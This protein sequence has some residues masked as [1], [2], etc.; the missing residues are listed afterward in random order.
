MPVLLTSFGVSKYLDKSWTCY[1]IARRQPKG[2]AYPTLSFLAPRDSH[3]RSLLLRLFKKNPAS[4]YRRAY[5]DQIERRKDRVRDWFREIDPNENIALCCWCGMSQNKS[6]DQVYS[7]GTFVCHT[8]LVGQ[9]LTKNRP[10][11]QVLVDRDRARYSCYQI[12]GASVFD[13][14]W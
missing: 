7:H 3:G 6:R 13:P 2:F 4:S 14:R 1:S 9:L 11:I 8:M 12:E 5:F 10:K